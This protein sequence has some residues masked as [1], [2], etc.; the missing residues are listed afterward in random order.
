M[1][2]KSKKLPNSKVKVKKKTLSESSSSS[3]DSCSNCSD[4]DS[5]SDSE[6]D[7]KTS[8]KRGTSK[9]SRCKSGPSSSGRTG[10]KLSATVYSKTVEESSDSDAPIRPRISMSKDPVEMKLNFKV[11][12]PNTSA[13]DDFSAKTSKS[14]VVTRK[15]S[16]PKKKEKK[17]D[18]CTDKGK[19]NPKTVAKRPRGRPRTKVNHIF[20]FVYIEYLHVRLIFITHYQTI[21]V[22]K[23]ILL[24]C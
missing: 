15:K 11:K 7:S 10:P 22:I 21:V 6:D 13:K 23:Y 20:N 8:K 17:P 1:K 4:D 16:S 2:N 9:S 12:S 19:A 24:T 18:S 5:S 14:G 3:D